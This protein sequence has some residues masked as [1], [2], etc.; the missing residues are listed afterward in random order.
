[1]DIVRGPSPLLLAA[2]IAND[3]SKQHMYQIFSDPELSRSFNNHISYACGLSQSYTDFQ[4]SNIWTV[5]GE[6]SNALTDCATWLNGRGVGARWDGTWG[7]TPNQ[8]VFGSCDGY[9]GSSSNFSDS[10]KQQMREYFEVQ[11]DV[12]EQVQGWIFWAWKVRRS[13]ARVILRPFELNKHHRPKAPMNGAIA[14]GWRG[15]GSPVTQQKGFTLISVRDPMP[16]IS[17]TIPIDT[18]LLPYRTSYL[19]IS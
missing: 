12:G 19:L 8:Q 13:L 1:M 14:K 15:A 11:I 18:M 7:N 4:S 5:V 16:S 2:S 6:W 17:L 10:F 3:H 9:T